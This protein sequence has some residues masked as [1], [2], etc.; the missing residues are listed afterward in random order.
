MDTVRTCTYEPLRL[1]DLKPPRRSW[2]VD[3]SN[4]HTIPVDTPAR[5]KPDVE[6]LARMLARGEFTESYDDTIREMSDD[7][8]EHYGKFSIWND[9]L[10]AS[11]RRVM[12]SPRLVLK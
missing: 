7:E 8:F 5:D 9:E 4:S 11:F 6:T 1:N 2:V 10:Q 3:L 12:V